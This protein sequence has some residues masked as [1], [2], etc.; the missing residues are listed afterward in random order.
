MTK[1]T[2]LN[3]KKLKVVRNVKET[4]QSLVEDGPTSENRPE[5][6]NKKWRT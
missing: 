5:Q 3:V 1:Y 2:K 6:T 4:I